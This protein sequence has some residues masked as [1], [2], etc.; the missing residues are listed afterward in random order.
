GR[1]EAVLGHNQEAMR[2]AQ[3]A[4]ELIPESVNASEGPIQSAKLAFVYAW[5]GD[6]DRAIAEYA[7]LLRKP[8]YT[9][10]G[11]VIENVH[12][13]KHHPAFAPLQGD[14]RFEALLND[15]RNNA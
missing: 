6:K 1:M 14:P 11:L 4:V 9:F 12:I 10:G 15:P 3:R 7:R 2:C 8:A 5:T 13:M